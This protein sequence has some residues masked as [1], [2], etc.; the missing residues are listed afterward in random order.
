MGTYVARRV[1]SGFGLLLA[2]TV[3]TYA[4]FFTIPADPGYFIVKTNHPTTAQLRAADRELGVDRPVYV[5]Y[6]RFV[7]RLVHG[8]LGNSYADGA[9][10]LS[11]V[12]ASLPVTA[13][14]VLGGAAL[15]ALT[16]VALGVLCARRQHTAVDRIVATLPLLGI[17]LHPLAVGLILRSVFAKHLPIA[18]SS[19][20]CSPIP[21]PGGCNG[22]FRWTSHLILPWITFALFMLPLYVRMV[23]TRVLETLDEQHVTVARAKG[24][25]ERRVVHAHVLPL[26]SPALVAMLAMDAGTALTAAIYIEV[27][28]SLPGLGQT[29]LTAQQGSVGLDLPVITGV[30]MVV[31]AAVITLNTVADILAVRLDPR[32]ELGSRRTAMLR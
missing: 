26:V 29:A 18:P 21:G 8:D 25:S 19:G 5:Q 3:V 27:A 4:I 1:A 31:A 32:L 13:S 12:R 6:A 24:A 28:F 9:P 23:R 14:I 22:V 10:V 20:Y 16:S 7:W 17:A 30:I 2:L 15:L 11:I